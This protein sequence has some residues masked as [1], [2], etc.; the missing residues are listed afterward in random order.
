MSPSEAIQRPYHSRQP[1]TDSIIEEMTRFRTSVLLSLALT[2]SVA[3]AGPAPHAGAAA[4]V[5]PAAWSAALPGHIGM[6]SPTV[7][8]ING[9]GVKDVIVADESGTLHAFDGSKRGVELPGWPV[10]VDPNPGSPVVVDSTPAVADLDGTGQ[11]S[12]VV[13]A[14]TDIVGQQGGVMAFNANG[15]VRW[16]FRTGAPADSPI[17]GVVSSVAIGDV[18]GDGHQ[19]VVFGSFDHHIYV[20]DRN[21]SLMPGG[22]FNN[23]D[24]IWSSPVLFDSEHAGRKN[25]FIGTDASGYEGCTG[26]FVRA[27]RYSGG[28]SEVWHVCRAEIFQ[29]SPAIVDLLGEGRADVVIGSGAFYKNGDSNKVWAFHADDGSPVPGWPQATN[30]TVF[31]SPVIG[32]LTGNGA[33]D[34]VVTTCGPGCPG[35]GQVWAFRPDGSVLW[36]VNPGAAEGGSGEMLSSAIL[37]NFDGDNANDVAVGDGG[38]FYVL[39]GEDGGR[40]FRLD[41]SANHAN[42]AAVAD[43]GGN[44][45]RQL[46]VSSTGTSG[47]VSA[48]P[49]VG[50]SAV[51]AWPTWRK[52]PAHDATLPV[53]PPTAGYW[54]TGSDGGLFAFGNAPYKGSAGSMTLTQPVVG[55][56]AT[57]DGMGYWMVASDGG[58]FAFGDAGFYGSTGAIHLNRPIVGMAA[59]ADGR[60][61][62]LVASDG[63]IFAFGDAGFHGSTG[64]IHLN[65]PIVGMAATPDGGGYWLVASDGGI[66]TFGDATFA[67]STGGIHLNRPI[68]AMAPTPDG[69]GYWLAASDGGIFAF[70]NAPFFGSA[71]GIALKQPV[72]AMSARPGGG[73][74]W[75]LASDGGI[76]AFGAAGF[77]GSTGALTLNRPIVV[78]APSHPTA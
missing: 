68:V 5:G 27:L 18:V 59:T 49:V 14:G 48:Y 46:I 41:T 40:M 16:R 25:I 50:A 37:A 22:V 63:G 47:Q 55:M 61:Y 67:G 23:A 6:S 74:Y 52:T 28:L 19:Y 13:G 11:L 71:G 29:S 12:V 9:D 53:P 43:M 35:G 30:A 44:V 38:A 17:S 3:V 7:A 39:R 36:H 1:R 73:G 10:K 64:A 60:G 42:S 66:F 20:L 56:A 58:I 8:D 33:H 70:G 31:G 65:Q 77:F 69:T 45:G 21:G 4:A 24:T 34:V 54:I 57:P 2:A 78:M 62:W 72:V 51:S 32:D 15:S 75:L 76:F 26:G